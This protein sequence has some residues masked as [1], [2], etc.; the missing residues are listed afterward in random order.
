MNYFAL[1]VT[2][3]WL[4]HW[5]VRCY[6]FGVPFGALSFGIP[7]LFSKRIREENR[8]RERNAIYPDK[9]QIFKWASVAALAIGS[10]LLVGALA[11]A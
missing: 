1:G 10:L 11:T 4:L 6:Y 9:S 2:H 8:E 3:E 5:G 7:Y